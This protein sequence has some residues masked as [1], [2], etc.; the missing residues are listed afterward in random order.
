M[1]PVKNGLK[2]VLST[3]IYNFA[4]P[5]TINKVHINKRGFN[6][7]RTY[8]GLVCADDVNIGGAYIMKQNIS[9]LTVA[10]KGNCEP[11]S[12]VGIVTDYRV[13]GPG[14]K[15]RWGEIFRT[16]PDRHWGPPS[17]LYNGYQVYPG[18]KTAGAWC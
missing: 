17:L 16:H 9:V 8:Q 5:H 2:I 1:F 7:Y 11:G 14:M 13:D 18:G 10:I 4:S 6:L 15:T 3:L 12:S